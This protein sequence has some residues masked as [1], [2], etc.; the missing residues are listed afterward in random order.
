[1]VVF[2]M[3]AICR[4]C[5]GPA[6]PSFRPYHFL[7]AGFGLRRP[8]LPKCRVYRSDLTPRKVG[9]LLGT[10]F[11]VPGTP[12]KPGLAVTLA[13]FRRVGSFRVCP[14]ELGAPLRRNGRSQNGPFCESL[15]MQGCGG[16]TG[17][18]RSLNCQTAA[19]VLVF[20]GVISSGWGSRVSQVAPPS[21]PFRCLLASSRG[22]DP[23]QPWKH[24]GGP[25]AA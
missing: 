6:G 25:R 18:E 21:H 1:M 17:K 19:A 10:S 16:P 4:N 15:P 14:P 9:V 11:K 23:P 13:G 3:T 8:R 20:I 7:C 12:L 24:P 5:S 2:G 22:G